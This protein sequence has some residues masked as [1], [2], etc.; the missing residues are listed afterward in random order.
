MRLQFIQNHIDR[1][2]DTKFVSG[3]DVCQDVQYRSMGTEH[4]GQHWINT[5]T[6]YYSEWMVELRKVH[7]G[8][9]FFGQ[10]NKEKSNRQLIKFLFIWSLHQQ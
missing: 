6:N 9:E 5:L 7:C 1:E 3:L 10:D 8:V 2:I 4:P